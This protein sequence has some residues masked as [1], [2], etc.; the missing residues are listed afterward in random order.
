MVQSESNK[1]NNN[2]INDRLAGQMFSLSRTNQ[3]KI[4][5]RCKKSKK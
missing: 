2:R 4:S 1:S 3:A 5:K